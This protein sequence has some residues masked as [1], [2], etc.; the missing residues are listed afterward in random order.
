MIRGVKDNGDDADILYTFNPIKPPG[1]MKNIIPNNVLYQKS[2]KE[3]FV[4][5][6]LFCTF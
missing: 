4:P 6:T 2:A 3:P 1:Y 5:Y